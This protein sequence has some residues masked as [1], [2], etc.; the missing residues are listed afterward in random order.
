ML[1]ELVA[2]SPRPRRDARRRRS[3]P[4]A[5][6][7]GSTSSPA[8]LLDPGDV[9]VTEVPTYLGALGALHWSG[10]PDRRRR[11]RRRRPAD[12]SAGGAA[13][14]RTAPEARLRRGRLRQP[15]GGDAVAAAPD[16]PRQRWPSG[17]ASSSSRTTPTAHCAGAGV[18]LAPVR[19]WSDRVVTLGTASKVV[20][21]GSAR[22]LAHRAGVAGAV[23]RHRQAGRRSAHVDAQPVDRRRS[24]GRRAVVR[25]PRQPAGRQLR[26]RAAP[27]SSRRSAAS[28][29]AD[30][31]R[32]RD[33]R[34]GARWPIRR[35]APRRC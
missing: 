12:R 35:S 1:R 30:R 8:T 18:R 3:S 14:C 21:P 27:R 34:V 24:A 22:R 31:A 10:V 20:A 16:P 19:A 29:D 25:G 17:S 23:D 28:V 9:V 32:R 7:R 11:R 15:D 4:P 5:R 13:A 33:V 2:E 26:G 6:S